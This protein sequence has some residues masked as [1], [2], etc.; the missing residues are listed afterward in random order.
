M[1][2]ILSGVIVVDLTQNIA[3]PFCTQILGDLGA[4]IIKVEKN[5]VGD[6]TRHWGGE[7]VQ[8]G[9]SAAFMAM[10]RNKKSIAIDRNWKGNG[11]KV[12]C[13]ND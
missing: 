11:T 10:N 13:R 2:G 3:G 5:T 8:P 1:S 7:G 12:S 6:D 9:E 4:T